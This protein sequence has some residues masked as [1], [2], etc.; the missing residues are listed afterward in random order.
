MKS[1][2]IVRKIVREVF[3]NEGMFSDFGVFK[4]PLMAKVH[5]TKETKY[6]S[7]GDG[8]SDSKDL[9]SNHKFF[10]RSS[11]IEDIEKNINEFKEELI[12]L[13]DNKITTSEYNKTISKILKKMLDFIKKN[14]PKYSAS[15]THDDN[16]ISEL[17]KLSKKLSEFLLK[18]A[19]QIRNNKLKDDLRI[20]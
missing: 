5:G 11:S 16:C 9:W 14:K 7:K 18:N 19:K 3:I 12:S 13:N 4:D 6:S 1:K 2:H 10:G 20:S 15:G 17:N 8:K